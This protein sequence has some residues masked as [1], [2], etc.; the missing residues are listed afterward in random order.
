MLRQL[1][2][3]LYKA[4]FILYMSLLIQKWENAPFWTVTNEKLILG[5]KNWKAP[6]LFVDSNALQGQTDLNFLN[7]FG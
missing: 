1:S 5:K 6:K 3:Q 4:M 7:L 2:A